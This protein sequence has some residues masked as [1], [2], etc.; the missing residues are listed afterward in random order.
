MT[1]EYRGTYFLYIFQLWCAPHLDGRSRTIFANLAHAGPPTFQCRMSISAGE[2]YTTTRFCHGVIYWRLIR[3]SVQRKKRRGLRRGFDV[4][5][6]FPVSNDDDD[7]YRCSFYTW[8]GYGLSIF[9]RF[10][11]SLSFT[12]FSFPLSWLR[13]SSL[14]SSS[15]VVVVVE[16]VGAADVGFFFSFLFFSLFDY[17][18]CF[19]QKNS[20]PQL[21]KSTCTH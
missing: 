10:P 11:F 12:T 1:N 6:V 20:L 5:Q 15:L 17:L 7:R 14:W 13:S 19:W 9:F 8:Q 2:P 18:F 4:R 21:V 16:L 3:L